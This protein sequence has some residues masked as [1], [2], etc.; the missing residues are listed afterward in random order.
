MHRGVGGCRPKMHYTPASALPRTVVDRPIALM[1]IGPPH[2][3]AAILTQVLGISVSASSLAR[4][5]MQLTSTSM[6][7]SLQPGHPQAKICI[8]LARLAVADKV[9]SPV[10]Q[11]T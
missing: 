6:A 1:A 7:A 4:Y 9:R 3:T 2:W 5:G 8:P 10:G 11:T